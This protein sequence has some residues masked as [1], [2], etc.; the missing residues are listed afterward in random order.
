MREYLSLLVDSDHFE[1]NATPGFLVN[2]L[3]GEELQYDRF[4]PPRVA[5]EFNNG[6]Q[7]DGPTAL[8]ASGRDIRRLR[9]RD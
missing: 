9:A 8:Y 2:P 6:P 4:Y 1:D 3:S 5:F 7:H